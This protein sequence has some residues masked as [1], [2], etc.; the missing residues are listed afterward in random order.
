VPEL[1]LTVRI[2]NINQGHNE[3][4]ARRSGRLQKYRLTDERWEGE[5]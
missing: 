4:I 5:I 2:Y 3:E 1:E